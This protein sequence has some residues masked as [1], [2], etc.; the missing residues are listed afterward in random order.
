M[1]WLENTFYAFSIFAISLQIVLLFL[2][3]SLTIFIFWKIRTVQKKIKAI[4]PM[5]FVTNFFGG[6]V[7]NFFSK[8]RKS[9]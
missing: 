8:K 6:L 5:L 2:L 9:R 3:T 1:N 7:G 4:T